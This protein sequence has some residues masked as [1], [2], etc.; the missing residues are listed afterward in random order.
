[1]NE[2]ILAQKFF[3]SVTWTQ[4]S[5]WWRTWSTTSSVM[6]VGACPITARYARSNLNSILRYTSIQ[7]KADKG[8]VIIMF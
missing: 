6:Y 8:V 3:L 7:Y 1:M 2:M 5:T 4:T